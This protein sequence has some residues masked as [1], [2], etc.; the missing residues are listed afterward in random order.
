MIIA[1]NIVVNIIDKYA[2]TSTE[3]GEF[4]I[5]SIFN[6]E[7]INPIVKN[8]IT[9]KSRFKRNFRGFRLKFFILIIN[10]SIIAF[11]ISILFTQK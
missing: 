5:I 9:L 11:L 4:E 3:R 2:K 6:Q 10:L 7:T 8:I 1:G